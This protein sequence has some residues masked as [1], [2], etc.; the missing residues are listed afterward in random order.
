MNV[1]KMILKWETYVIRSNCYLTN[2]QQQ[3]TDK[4]IRWEL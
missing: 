1:A 2:K 4:H 3:V